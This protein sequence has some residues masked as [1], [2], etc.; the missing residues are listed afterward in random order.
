MTVEE[1][2]ERLK[3]LPQQDE[4]RLLNWD[5]KDGFSAVPIEGAGEDDKGVILY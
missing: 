5:K 2:I 3:E 4:V 1:L